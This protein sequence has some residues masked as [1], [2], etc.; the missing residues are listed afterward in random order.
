MKRI[1]SLAPSIT[2]ILFGIGAQNQLVGVSKYCKDL[3]PIGDLPQIGDCWSA[4]PEEVTALKPDL[5]IGG[6]PYRQETMQ[7]LI[8]IGTPFF[9]TYPK[10]LEDIYND[11]FWLGELTA[12]AY[13]AESLVS[14]MKEQIES[15]QK[16]IKNITHRPR[17]YCEEWMK[18]LICSSGW[19]KQLVEIAGG[20]FVPDRSTFVVE[21]KEV[22]EANPEIIVM[23]WCGAGGKS[24]PKKI[25]EREG[26]SVID[27][28]KTNRIY[29]LPDQYFNS[30]CQHLVTGLR[31]MS[32]VLHPEI[33][34]AYQPV[35]QI[36]EQVSEPTNKYAV[37]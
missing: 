2:A 22:I 11:I 15:V 25:I 8:T 33:F 3:S 21:P 5:V 24:N 7:K 34:G 17:V 14:W 28:V 13:E 29:P 37:S 12:H 35:H 4:T 20:D 18:P 10:H 27:A 31:L 36:L 23:A 9:L 26:W 30:P 19:V 16:R 6:L 32:Q 1:V